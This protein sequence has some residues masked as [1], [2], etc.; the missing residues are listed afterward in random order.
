MQDR[1]TIGI[2][3]YNGAQRLDW[4]LK[5]LSMRTT[6]SIPFDIVVVDDGSPNVQ[7]TRDVCSRYSTRLIEHGSNKGI[8]AAWNTL[9]NAFENR[10]VVLIN[11]DVIVPSG[12]WLESLTYCLDNSPNVGVVGES[13]HA[14]LPDE[15][16]ALLAGTESDRNVT[17]RDPMKVADASRRE[18][19]EDTNPGRVMCP[20]GQLFAFRRNDHG[21]IGGF[22]ERFKS[23]YEE[24]DFGTSMAKAGLIG[25]QLTWPFCWHLWSATFAQNPELQAGQ[26]IANSRALY[27]Q[28]WQVPDG[29]HEFDYTNPK[30][31][32]GI[33]DVEVKFLRK[34]GARWRGTLRTDGAFV[35]GVQEM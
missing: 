35:D 22:D 32:G 28:K 8:P 21:R 18:K 10:L 6:G 11:D 20:T 33:G 1:V 16:G 2:P 5:S 23:F 12:G 24:S 3:T 30:Y 29:I 7:G 27:R 19:Y 9:T 31:L 17:P 13:W 26:R 4:A 25:V 15:A 14:F 34:G